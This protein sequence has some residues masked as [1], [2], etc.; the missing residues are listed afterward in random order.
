VLGVKDRV[1]ETLR[2]YETEI[3]DLSD[4]EE[5][6]IVSRDGDLIYRLAGTANSVNPPPDLV[7]NNI[8][9]HNHPSGSFVLSIADVR[10]IVRLDG[11]E[12]RAVT[13]NGRFSSL[14]KRD[15]S[16]GAALV[17]EM[18]ARFGGGKLFFEANERA[19]KAYGAERTAE[20]IKL[21]AEK[22]FT[23]WLKVNA[24]QYGYIFTEGII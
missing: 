8:F 13:R 1:A 2:K 23:E 24:P 12:V 7:K 5:G 3:K 21:E 4:Y 6:V 17:A 18:D 10:T 15:E 22:A 11:Y 19:L 20:Q 16:E 14:K 9:T